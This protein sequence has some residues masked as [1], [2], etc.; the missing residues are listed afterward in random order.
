MQPAAWF[1]IA[2]AAILVIAVV[3]SRKDNKQDD[4]KNK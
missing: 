1:L 4:S 2:I 3:S